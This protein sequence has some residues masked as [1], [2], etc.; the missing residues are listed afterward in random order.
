MA[1]VSSSD[2][3]TPHMQSGSQAASGMG[4]HTSDPKSTSANASSSADFPRE[5]SIVCAKHTPAA[6]ASS[7]SKCSNGDCSG[8]GM[9]CPVTVS[10]TPYL[11]ASGVAA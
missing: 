3:V 1:Y 9:P 2:S 8:D 7:H 4:T 10:R 11:G 5:S 6:W